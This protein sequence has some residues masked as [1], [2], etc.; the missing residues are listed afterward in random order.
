[1][2]HLPLLLWRE[3]TGQTIPTSRC[4]YQAQRETP[5]RCVYLKETSGDTATVLYG[6][7]VQNSVDQKAQLL[8]HVCKRVC[9]YIQHRIK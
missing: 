1:M 6:R 2:L 5:R 8:N 3:V 4:A 9:T 7:E